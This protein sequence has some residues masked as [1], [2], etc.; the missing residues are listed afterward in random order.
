MAFMT[1]P[2]ARGAARG[3]PPRPV[4]AFLLYREREFVFVS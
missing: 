4:M 2:T 3:V 1:T